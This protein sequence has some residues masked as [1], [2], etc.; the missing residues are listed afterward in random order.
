MHILDALWGEIAQYKNDFSRVLIFLPSNLAIKSVEKMIVDNIG[1][2]VVLP[3]LVPLGN[4]IDDEEDERSI[5]IISNQERTI[6]LAKLLSV[7]ANI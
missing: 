6:I 3:K 1:H 7:D 5:N 2:A 4:G